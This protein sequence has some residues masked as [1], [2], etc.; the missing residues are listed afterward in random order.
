M[1]DLHI[2]KKVLEEVSAISSRYTSREGRWTSPSAPSAVPVSVVSSIPSPWAGA[3]CPTREVLAG[4]V[5][6]ELWLPSTAARGRFGLGPL[7]GDEAVR[8]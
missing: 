3:L 2:N 8:F 4:A 5:D 6:E 7:D 1:L